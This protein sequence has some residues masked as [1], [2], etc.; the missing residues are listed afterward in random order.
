M[1]KQKVTK[2]DNTFLWI[3]LGFALFAILLLVGSTLDL[4]VEP[5]VVDRSY[6]AN[7]MTQQFVLNDLKSPATCEFERYT[8]DLVNETTPNVFIVTSYVDSQ[9]SFGAMI[10]TYYIAELKYN[11][12]TDRWTMFD[13]YYY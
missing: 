13:L 7:Y 2:K 9:N 8:T 10:R 6:Y 11:L 12:D 5:K 3:G 1:K 4:E